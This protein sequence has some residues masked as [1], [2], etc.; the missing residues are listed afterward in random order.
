VRNEE[1]EKAPPALSAELVG[2]GDGGVDE[3]L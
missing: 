1:V 2:R 3:H